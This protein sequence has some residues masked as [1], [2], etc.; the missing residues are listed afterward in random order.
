MAE[1]ESKSDKFKRL[2]TKRVANAIKKI[3]LIGHLSASSYESTPEEVD[4][5]MAALQQAL[6]GAKERFS[7]KKT[8]ASKFE[9]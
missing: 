4:K 7:K 5:I 9:L 1:V 6:D 8:S 3:E 2:A